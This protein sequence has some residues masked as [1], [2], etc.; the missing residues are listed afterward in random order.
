MKSNDG[1]GWKANLQQQQQ[2][3][4][5]PGQSVQFNRLP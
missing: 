1:N 2:Q 3:Q 5:P 4:Q